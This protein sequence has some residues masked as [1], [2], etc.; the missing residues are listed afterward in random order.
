MK[1]NHSQK[2]HII[3]TLLLL[4]TL[5]RCT[6]SR[7]TGHTDPYPRLSWD[8][9]LTLPPYA[10]MNPNKG[11]AGAF[12][13]RVGEYL[14][15]AGGAN[16]PQAPVWEGGAKQWWS[17]LYRIHPRTGET[18]IYENFLEHPLAYGLTIQQPEGI[19]CIG[20]NDADCCYNRLYLITQDP[21]GNPQLIT[22]PYPPLPVPL[23]NLAGT[24]LGQKIY[25][26]GG[27]EEMHPEQSTRHFLMLDLDQPQTGWQQ[28]PAWPG[29]D[30]AYSICVAQA[31]EIYLF[32]GRSFGPGRQMTI[33]P[34]GFK[35]NPHTQTWTPLE[36]NY[37]VMAGTAHPLDNDK[38]LLIG[39]VKTLIPAAP[40]HPGFTRTLHLYNTT[41]HTLDSIG[42]APIPLPVTTTLVQHHD[43]LY[44]PSGEIRPGQRTPRIHKAIISRPH[45][46]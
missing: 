33:H 22:D 43:T 6:P 24:Q 23:S 44:I 41:T 7:Q 14:V 25:L 35:Y 45:T 32:G 10:G 12:A 42:Q 46:R 26:A 3:L 9:T 28:L 2:H 5:C 18:T 8:T 1:T 29:A 37:P 13:G 21:D 30:R 4:L 31:G 27:Q 38:I 17:T 19:L 34:D 40:D 20:G 11:L 36:G 16:F 15:I 39:G